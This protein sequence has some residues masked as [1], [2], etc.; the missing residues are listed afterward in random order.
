MTLKPGNSGAPAEAPAA[1]PAITFESGPQLHGDDGPRLTGGDRDGRPESASICA[2]LGILER[3]PI[4]RRYRRITAAEV[5]VESFEDIEPRQPEIAHL[6]GEPVDDD[7]EPDHLAVG[8]EAGSEDEHRVLSPRGQ[9]LRQR[10]NLEPEAGVD[11]TRGL[12]PGFA[13]QTAIGA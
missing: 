1:G 5:R 4:H 8:V 9:R 2:D 3:V 6:A 7:L 11:G 12:R 13:G 10:V